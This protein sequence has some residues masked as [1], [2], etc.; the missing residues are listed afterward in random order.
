MAILRWRPAGQAVERWDPFRDLSEIQSEMNR[1]FGGALGQRAAMAGFDRGWAP[2]VDM[3]ETNDEL[4]LR[5]ELPGMNEKDIDL[6]ITGDVLVLR[7]ERAPDPTVNQENYFRGERWSGR[8]ERMFTLP[9][10]VDVDKI[11]ARVEHGVLTVTLP[12][13]ERS[14]PRQIAV[15]K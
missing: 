4:V 15:T 12:K 7:G 9:T 11:Q 2:A 1:L 5:A 3:Y 6:S 14:K 8:F 13:S 10:N